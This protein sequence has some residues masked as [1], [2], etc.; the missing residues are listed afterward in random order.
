MTP[1]AAVVALDVNSKYEDIM[2]IVLESG[3]SRLPVT[4]GTADN[5]IG[6]I[7]VKDLLNFWENKELIILKDMIYQPTFVTG[8]RKV[9]ELLKEFQ[10]EYN[11][12]PHSSLKYLTP[13][14]VFR[15]KQRTGS[16]W[17]VG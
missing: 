6:V 12:T 14:E 17:A 16:V 15:A 4:S 7:N 8:S 5:I 9:S 11:N 3:Y 1:K 10:N 13:K 2:R